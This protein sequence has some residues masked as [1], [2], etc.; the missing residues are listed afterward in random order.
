MPETFS[1]ASEFHNGHAI[2]SY[3]SVGKWDQYHIIDKNGKEIDK[4]F[5]TLNLKRGSVFGIDTIYTYDSETEENGWG[6]SMVTYSQCG[7]ALYSWVHS[8]SDE[9]SKWGFATS[10]WQTIHFREFDEI[11]NTLFNNSSEGLLHVRIGDKWGYINMQGETVIKPQFDE[12]RPFNSGYAWVKSSDKWGLI[13]KKGCWQIEPKFDQHGWPWSHDLFHVK[14][15]DGYAIINKKGEIV[16]DNRFD[17]VY[18]S[19]KDGMFIMVKVGYDYA[20]VDD[21]GN[22]KIGPYE[23]LGMFSEGLARVGFHDKNGYK[24][25]YVDVNG[26]IAIEPAF[27]HS[28]DFE[29]GLAW[30]SMD[31]DGKYGYIDKTGK[32]VIQPQFDGCSE[33]SNGLAK[34]RHGEKYGIVDKTGKYLLDTQYDDIECFKDG[35]ARINQNGKL[36]FVDKTGKI[37]L[38]PKYDYLEYFDKGLARFEVGGKMGY[39]NEKFEVVYMEK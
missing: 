15:E 32:F 34:V 18:G 26:K 21:L 33:F 25:G 35:L 13:D 27:W 10:D 39:I 6:S 30:A 24:E 5:D 36:G 37:V 14:L 20:M 28:S 3:S 22:V 19:D 31:E 9:E 4:V 29:E 12:V 11:G 38:D 2:V 1:Y 8:G 16:S 7:Y 23:E 17:D